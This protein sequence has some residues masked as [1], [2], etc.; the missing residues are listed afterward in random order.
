MTDDNDEAYTP[1]GPE[2]E[3]RTARFMLALFDRQITAHEEHWA[4]GRMQR[5]RDRRTG[6]YDVTIDD[7]I[8]E[9]RKGRKKWAGRVARLARQVES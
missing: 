3:L 1:T 8:D 6:A 7:R 9:L 4:K 2:R 5:R